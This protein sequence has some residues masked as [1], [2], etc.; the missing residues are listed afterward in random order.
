MSHS[1]QGLSFPASAGQPLN[2][3]NNEWFIYN[4]DTNQPPA[5]TSYIIFDATH[6]PKSLH[7]TNFVLTTSATNS[8]NDTAD[9]PLNEMTT[10]TNAVV[11][12]TPLNETNNIPVGVYLDGNVWAIF[13]EDEST[14]QFGE[15]FN[16]L[17]YPGVIH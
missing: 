16:V 5:A 3:L 14:M 11:F 7:A 8:S 10:N 12:V 2:P 9:F 1:S 13:N 4:E 17:I 6:L 15:K